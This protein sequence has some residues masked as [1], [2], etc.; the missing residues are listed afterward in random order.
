MTK[1]QD[2]AAIRDGLLGPFEIGVKIALFAN[3]GPAIII[4]IVVNVSVTVGLPTI[5]LELDYIVIEVDWMQ[6]DIG[7]GRPH[8]V[9][10]AIVGLQR[11][12]VA[13]GASPHHDTLK[14]YN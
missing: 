8:T 2:E 14:N 7:T 12:L 1:L 13:H 9:K 3:I 10:G 11:C 4:A 6:V 5:T